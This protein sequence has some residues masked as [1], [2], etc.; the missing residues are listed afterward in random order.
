MFGGCLWD[1]NFPLRSTKNKTLL[2]VAGC[3]ARVVGHP[4]VCIYLYTYTY[5]CSQHLS[6]K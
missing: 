4:H 1:L 2:Q 6:G 3:G 5:M